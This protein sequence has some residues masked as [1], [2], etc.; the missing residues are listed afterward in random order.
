[1]NIDQHD[2]CPPMPWP[3]LGGSVVRIDAGATT[4]REAPPGFATIPPWSF[5]QVPVTLSVDGMLFPGRRFPPME[6]QDAIVPVEA[7]EAG[8]RRNPLSGL[9]RNALARALEFME[10]NLGEDVGLDD[11]AR[12]ACV[13]RSHFARLFRV[14]MDDSPMGYLLRL[15]IERAKTLLA[16]NDQSICAIALALG[17]FDQSHFSRTFRRLTGQSP[18][19][20]ARTA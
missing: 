9:S 20:F 4:A 13:S 7:R 14:S 12:A 16:R 8:T 3:P 11:I 18:S 2:S 1:M 17:F 15:R 5:N 6:P 10:R 19:Q